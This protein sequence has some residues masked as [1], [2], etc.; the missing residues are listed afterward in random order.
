M[1]A[2]E[3]NELVRDVI[4]KYKQ[5]ISNDELIIDGLKKQ[6]DMLKCCGNC[7]WFNSEWTYT[8]TRN[9]CDKRTFRYP[10]LTDKCSSWEYGETI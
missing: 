4:A 5:V 8:G 9:T 6:I 1:A 7:K 3:T 2:A 10:E